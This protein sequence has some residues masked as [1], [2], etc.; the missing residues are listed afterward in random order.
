MSSQLSPFDLDLDWLESHYNLD[1]E[2][3][4]DVCYYIAELCSLGY[5]EDDARLEATRKLKEVL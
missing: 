5:S 3:A 4:D 1:D 2:Q